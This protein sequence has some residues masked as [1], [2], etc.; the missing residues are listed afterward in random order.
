MEMLNEAIRDVLENRGVK[1]LVLN[2]GTEVAAVP[3]NINLLD[4]EQF[5]SHPNLIRATPTMRGIDSF[6]RY[7]NKHKTPEV[8]T[9]FV[10]PD[11]SKLGPNCKLAT[12]ILDYHPGVNAGADEGETAPH[13]AAHGNHVVTLNASPSIAYAKLMD[14]DGKLFA[15][16]EFAKHVEEIARHSTSLPPAEL[17]EIV[18][19]LQLAAKGEFRSLDDDFTGSV[20]FKFDV[21]VSASAG[22]REKKITVPQHVEFHVVLIEGLEPVSVT[23]KLR[24]RQPRNPGE[25]VAIGFSIVDRSWME[26]LAIDEVA[27]RIGSDTELDVFTGTL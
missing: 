16:D 8:S 10:V 27:S 12:A 14:L 22:T 2:D 5:K 4:L 24:Y 7:V 26:K 13:P 15:Q 6:V 11:L 9:I 25:H 23:C 17:I 1:L 19:S 20:D 21:Q 18:Q 3:E